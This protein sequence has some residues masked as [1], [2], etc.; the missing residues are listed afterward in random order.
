MNKLLTLLVILFFIPSSVVNSQDLDAPPELPTREENF[1]EIEQYTQAIKLNPK[2]ERAYYSRAI[3][4]MYIKDYVKAIADFNEL[5]KINSDEKY[6]YYLRG[7]AKLYNGDYNSAIADLSI[8]MR[9]DPNY[10]FQDD[11]MDLLSSYS[12]E[13]AV[14]QKTKMVRIE[15]GSFLMGS[16]ANEPE[17]IHNEGPQ[18]RVNVSAFYIGKFQ[19]TQK[20]YRDIMGEN[21]SYCKGDNHP[22]ENV[23]WYKAIEY[24]NA[25]SRREGLTPVYTIDKTRYDLNNKSE[26]DEVK[27]VVT[28]NRNANGYRLPT[29]A[30]WEYAC[31]A[32]TNTP[33]NTGNNITASQANYDGKYP[34]NKNVKGVSRNITTGVGSF[35][36]TSNPWGLYDMHGNVWEWCW[37]W[38]GD[39]SNA[40]QTDPVGAVS[41]SYR[42]A[43][44]GCY[45]SP[46][47]GARSAA[48]NYVNPSY[49]NSIVNLI[50]L[51]IVRSDL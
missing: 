50:G 12:F 44:G 17:R 26:W 15:A 51:R 9:I 47:F 40:V 41:G 18:H 36:F 20:E 30:E 11:I 23:S 48:R 5:I 1:K 39:Y 29:E 25:L 31:R 4:Y 34:Y 19:V 2:N 7:T 13:L 10:Y 8:V 33:F 28:W 37:D 42:V 16:P 32:G 35:I 27:W 45:D 49:A 21:P 38:F 3:A 43:R 46:A 24:C 6:F 22:V 14:R